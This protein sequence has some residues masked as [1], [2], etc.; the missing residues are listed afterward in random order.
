M[1]P[2]MHRIDRGAEVAFGA[3][4]R[5]IAQRGEDD[6]VVVG[7]GQPRPDEPYRFVR[8]P[9]VSRTHFGRAPKF[10]PLRSEYA[11]EDATFVAGFLARYR[12]SQVDLTVTC[13]YPFVNWML[14]RWPPLTRRPA[15]VYV[16]ENGDWPAFSDA[17]EFRSFRCDGLV[18][19]NPLYFERN[20]ERWNCTLIPNGIHPDLFHP[21]PPNR[22]ALGLPT[23]GLLVTMVSALV[24]TKRVLEGIRAV[25]PIRGAHLVVAGD[26]PLR[27]EV[28]A[29]ADELMP[30]RFRRLVLTQAQMPDLYRSADVFLHTALHE[31]FGN[32]Y[33]EAMACGTPVV[34]HDY[35]VTRWI[36]GETPGL[37]DARDTDALT[38]AIVRSITHDEAGL[39][40]RA[41]H[42]AER[43]AW[44]TIS[45]QY[46]EFFADVVERTRAAH[47]MSES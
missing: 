1:L 20:R 37:V 30:G 18:C 23:D 15:H 45:D 29:L 32:V 24:V 17:R 46:R 36:F 6:V 19:T 5:G 2:G 40:E 47:Q 10:P 26:G 16:T 41:R 43:F 8:S 38:T 11:Y 25:A 44:G 31:S 13:S 27:R 21:G 35:A 4:A 28:D 9:L 7:S 34:A 42:T 3:I 39:M 22:A 33:I 12:P 14:T